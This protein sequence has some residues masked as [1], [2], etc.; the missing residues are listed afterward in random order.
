[1]SLRIRV[2]SGLTIV[3]FAGVLQAQ[4][5][6][7]LRP[8]R[9]STSS[10]AAPRFDQALP[11]ATS[12]TP[13]PTP[14]PTPSPAPMS[15]SVVHPRVEAESLWPAPELRYSTGRSALPSQR[16][17]EREASRAEQRKAIIALR[18]RQGISLLRPNVIDQRRFGTPRRF[19]YGPVWKNS[20]EKPRNSYE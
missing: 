19:F 2:L 11:P 17:S 13:R 9:F 18:K 16:V 7:G 20:S 6:S 1:M 3:A 15:A 12:P 4:A 10:L 5:P 14:R 8:T